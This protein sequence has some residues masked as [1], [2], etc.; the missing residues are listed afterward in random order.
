MSFLVT[1]VDHEDRNRLWTVIPTVVK[2][3]L[4]DVTIVVI[5]RLFV[6]VWMWIAFLRGCLKHFLFNFGF[7]GSLKGL[8]PL[9]INTTGNGDVVHVADHKS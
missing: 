4:D 8:V 1:L 3:G 2:Y 6:T 5:S 7:T 9:I